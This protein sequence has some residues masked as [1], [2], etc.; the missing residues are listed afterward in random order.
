MI[1]LTDRSTS[2]RVVA[3]GVGI[4]DDMFGGGIPSGVIV[5]VF[6]RHGTGKT[7]MLLQAACRFAIYGER[8]RVLYVDTAG[9]F[10]PERIMEMATSLTQNNGQNDKISEQQHVNSITDILDAISVAR[11]QSVSEQMR[12]IEKLLYGNC[13]FDLVVIDSLTDLF[14]YEYSRYGDL[15]EKSQKFFRYMRNLARLAVHYGVTVMTSNMVR[16]FDDK[17]VENMAAEVDLFSHIKIHLISEKDTVAQKKQLYGYVSCAIYDNYF[18]QQK[19]V[20]TYHDHNINS[21]KDAD[22]IFSYKILT[23]GIQTFEYGKV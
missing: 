9:T 1:E 5:D 6:G 12:L 4:L 21:K 22:A 18:N 20:T 13:P 15:R 17:E 2:R 8:R 7:Q 14:S 11:V 10:R 16:V 19:T 23:S 3:V